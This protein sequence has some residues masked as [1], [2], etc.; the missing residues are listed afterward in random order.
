MSGT[1]E[2]AA[3]FK[4]VAE[5]QNFEVIP[6]QEELDE[7]IRTEFN[8]EDVEGTFFRVIILRED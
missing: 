5:D 4:I 6:I 1:Q 2:L 3:V 8:V 7:D